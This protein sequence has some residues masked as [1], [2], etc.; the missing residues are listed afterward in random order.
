MSDLITKASWTKAVMRQHGTQIIG[1]DRASRGTSALNETTWDKWRQGG[2][3][4][5]HETAWDNMRRIERTWDSMRQHGT[6]GGR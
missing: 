1:S 6:T 4:E 5:Q 3:L 2:R